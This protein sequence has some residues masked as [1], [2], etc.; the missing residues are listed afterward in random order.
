MNRVLSEEQRAR[1]NEY[2]R[3]RDAKMR[4]LNIELVREKDRVK[5]RNRRQK[6]RDEMREYDRLR[7]AQNREE[8]RAKRAADYAANVG[9][10]RDK[11][12]IY[13]KRRFSDSS[14]R[15][16]LKMALVAARGRC[17]T[18]G[19]EFDLTEADVGEPTHC[20]V[21]GLPLDMSK[22]FNDGNTFCPS[23]DRIDPKKGY[24]KGNVRVVI[25]AYNLAKHC[26]NDESVL[27][28][29]RA[30]VRKFGMGD[31]P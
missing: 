13:Q 29:A 1:K 20:A 22:S 28:M 23:L 6:F 9:G 15:Y 14:M 7:Y 19:M 18:R 10:V 24:V 17:K 25:H 5:A 12:L 8:I 3:Q 4:E 31:E 11:A 30:L 21:T 27:T 16:R 26:G 2:N